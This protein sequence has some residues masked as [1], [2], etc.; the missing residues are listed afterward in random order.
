MRT[1]RGS[2][3]GSPPSP[4]PANVPPAGL[5][6]PPQQFGSTRTCWC[7]FACPSPSC[8]GL[9]PFSWDRGKAASGTTRTCRCLARSK[10]AFPLVQHL[11]CA[12]QQ[13]FQARC[14]FSLLDGG[15]LQISWGKKPQESR[16]ERTPENA[17]AEFS[18]KA[19]SS[20][21]NPTSSPTTSFLR[22]YC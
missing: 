8:S 6:S 9:A 22:F 19:T 1:A 10:H 11:L 12:D 7:P 14:C 20:P 4:V 18:A 17:G 21:Q 16:R 5:G 13:G 15:L 2:L 3:G